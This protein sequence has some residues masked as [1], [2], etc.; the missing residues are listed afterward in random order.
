MTVTHPTPY[1]WSSTIQEFLSTPERS[2][3]NSLTAHH[4]SCM[5]EPADVA[6]LTAWENCF[7]VLHDQFSTLI[8]DHPQAAEWAVIFEY[9]LPRERGRRPDVVVLAGPTIVVL[10]FKDFKTLRQAHID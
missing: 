9:E 6:Q 3:L 4:Q 8:T 2:W 5:S 1:A 10:E 7:S